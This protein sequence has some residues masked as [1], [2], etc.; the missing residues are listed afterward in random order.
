MILLGAAQKLVPYLIRDAQRQGAQALRN[1]AY[2]FI[3]RIDERRSATQHM[4][5]L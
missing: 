4:G 3:R 2:L 5:I 1:A